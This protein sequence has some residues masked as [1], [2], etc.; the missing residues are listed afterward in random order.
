MLQAPALAD[1]AGISTSAAVT[2]AA[3]AQERGFMRAIV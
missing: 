1:P 2:E 3:S